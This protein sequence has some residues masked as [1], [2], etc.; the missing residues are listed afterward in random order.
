MD[1]ERKMKVEGW[2]DGER[3]MKRRWMDGWGKE[4]EK[5]MDGWMD[6]ERKMKRRWMDGCSGMDVWIGWMEKIKTR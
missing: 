4:D 3:K 2:M 6:G 5:K 1:G